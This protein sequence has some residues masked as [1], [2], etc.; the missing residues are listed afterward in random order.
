VEERLLRRVRKKALIYG[1]E[2]LDQDEKKI[3]IKNNNNNSNTCNNDNFNKEE[4]SVESSLG[5]ENDEHLRIPL[6]LVVDMYK[7]FV[8]PLTKEVEVLYLLNR[9]N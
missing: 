4:E 8:I 1:Q 2:I 3:K 6:D 7:R 9:L 5:G